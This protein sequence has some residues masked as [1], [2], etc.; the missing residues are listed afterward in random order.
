LA[1]QDSSGNH[2]RA[3]A[4]ELEVDSRRD[5]ELSHFKDLMAANAA[6]SAMHAARVSW[7]AGRTREEE[8]ALAIKLAT[9][10]VHTAMSMVDLDLPSLAEDA[11]ATTAGPVLP[12]RSQAAHAPNR[13]LSSLPT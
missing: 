5:T 10:A 1:G 9:E 3:L 8:N 13:I 6:R 11:L 7:L 4:T 2:A 12:I